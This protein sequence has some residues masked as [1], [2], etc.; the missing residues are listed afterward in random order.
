MSGP[1]AAWIDAISA[2]A[3][4]AVNPV[5]TGVLVRA[6]H[7]EVRDRWQAILWDLL[8]PTTSH[9]KLP[10]SIAADRLL[11]GID[12]TAT[13]QTGRPVLQRG[14]LAEAD[15]GVLIAVMAERMA[16][17]TAAH[18]AAVIDT[19]EVGLERDGLS[20]RVPS[21]FGMIAL[22]E[23]IDDEHAPLSLVDRLAFHLDLNAVSRAD[24]TDTL[25][26]PDI[27]AA[28]ALL[29]QVRIGEAAIEVLCAAAVSLGI[30]SLRAPL[31]A[32]RVAR[33]AAAL[34]GE[35]LVGERQ[36]ACAARLVLGPRATI[37]PAPEQSEPE[38]AP[39]DGSE[40]QDDEDHRHDDSPLQD[41]VL[42]AAQAA[43][44]PDLLKRLQ[45]G[46]V[47]RQR[48]AGAGRQGL[49]QKAPQRGRPIGVRRG[50][51]RSGQRLNV[52]E[53]LR[54]AAPWQKLR[55]Q[56]RT[57]G[58]GDDARLLIQ[59]DDIR[60]TRFKSR[61][62]TTTIFVVDASGSSALQRLA[63]VKGAVELLLA[64]CYIRRDEVALIAFR[65]HSAELILPPTRSLA[66]A[67][68]SLAALPGGGG[69]PL[70][71]A[72]VA[73]TEL[74]LAVRAKGQAPTI[75]LMTD[76][77]ANVA[78]APDGGRAAAEAEAL[79]AARQLGLSGIPVVLVDSS[80]R[81]QASA[82]RLA[83]AMHARYVALPHADAARLSRAVMVNVPG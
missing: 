32:S 3:L 76:G 82:G 28:R 39:Q 45:D 24:L 52:L 66:R 1:S 49:A 25:F 50:E 41:R 15:G 17:S 31:L 73:A 57:D 16:I 21:S 63:E 11:G 14:L 69:T 53:T 42:Q 58:D 6:G 48:Q 61:T 70:S 78:K 38:P 72:I 74:A 81:P 40:S 56:A 44:P 35:T 33:L 20:L 77:R 34:D 2:A 18:L 22:D 13:L 62:G 51:W 83:E 4:F 7:G 47:S 36:L 12:L 8:P 37:I 5:A 27:I 79:A 68:R 75:V 23:G 29:P 80:P 60:L 71:A 54:T 46:G 64:D 43:I 59:K 30:A 65:G 10:A 9:R 19:G 67:K 26:A 55:Q